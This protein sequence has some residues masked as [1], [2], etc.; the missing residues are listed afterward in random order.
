SGG[1]ANL[2]TP[3]GVIGGGVRDAAGH[4]AA[5]L[6][7]RL[8]S[9]YVLRPLPP[10]PTANPV[11]TDSLVVGAGSRGVVVNPALAG[12]TS[13]SYLYKLD[14]TLVGNLNA[15]IP[16]GA[17][18]NLQQVSKVDSLGRVAGSGAHNGQPGLFYLTPVAAGGVSLRLTPDHGT[19]RSSERL[20]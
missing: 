15:M 11:A 7:I 8:G 1:R 18:W 12:G 16:S 10:L 2:V 20:G 14:G 3:E 6:W 5:A 17:G 19:V 9:S 4:Y 13:S